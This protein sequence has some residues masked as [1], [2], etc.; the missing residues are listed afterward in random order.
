MVPSDRVREDR[1]LT[2]RVEEDGEDLLV[3]AFGELEA[4]NAKTLEEELRLAMAVNATG[5]VL[6]LSGVT[7]IDSAGMR[8]LLV[9][10]RRSLRTGGG[11]CLLRGSD[12]V[13]RAIATA[14]V[15]DSLPLAD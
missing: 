5:V 15:E 2:V 3:R 11:F 4:C 7:L 6:D 14:R 1:K 12:E 8:V 13:D 10:A 9:T